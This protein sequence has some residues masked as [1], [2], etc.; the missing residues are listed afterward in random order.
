VTG[1]T[2][3]LI[4]DDAGLERLIEHLRQ[5]QDLVLGPQLRDGAVV[6]DEIDS[7]ADLPRGVAEEQQPGHYRLTHTGDGRY[8]AQTVGPQSWKKFLHPPRQRLW[9]TVREGEATTLVPEAADAQSRAFLGVKPCELAAIAIQDRVFT[10]G[11]YQ[12]AQYAGRRARSFIVV[13]NCSRAAA[14]CFCTSMA[15]GP[16]AEKGFDLALT[17]LGDGRILVES[18][19]AA[20][21][22]ALSAVGGAAASK[23]D[24]AAARAVSAETARQ[25]SKRLD[26]QGLPELLKANPNAKRWDEVAAR[27]LNCANC[28][29]V[30]PTCFCISGEDS[31]DLEGKETARSARWDSCFTADHSYIHGGPVRPSGRSQY[32]QWLTHKLATWHDQFDMPGCTGCGRCITWCPVGIDITEEAAAIRASAQQGETVHGS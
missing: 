15:S 29:M 2:P 11:A 16:C 9:R 20:G 31:S 19:S 22:S 24:V 25:V 13:A 17:E 3:K 1:A 23:D 26:T 8:F 7:I 27:C 21:A 4:L 18:G 5:T 12:D 28:T 30:C 14:T 10:G 32:R 6:L